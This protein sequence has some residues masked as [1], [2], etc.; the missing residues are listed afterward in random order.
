MTTTILL[1]RHADVHNPEH[2]FYGRLPRFR[3]SELGRRQ[4]AFVR[5]RLAD[6]PIACFYTSPMLRARL[7]AQVLAEAHPGVPV[8]RA[9]ELTEVRTGWMGAA[10]ASLPARINL[11]E[12]PHSQGDETIPEVARRVDRLISR[13]ARRHAGQKICCV[14]HGDPIVIAHALYKRLPLKLDSIRMDWYPQKG[15]LTTLRFEAGADW[16]TVE[17][18]D[19]IGQLAPELK[20]PY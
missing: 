10:N 18:I 14:S 4:A 5:D 17:Y 8:R 9:I 12:P 7:T 3:I 16:P 11:Y 19:L 2:V 20:A 13:L 1:V 15:S 6:A